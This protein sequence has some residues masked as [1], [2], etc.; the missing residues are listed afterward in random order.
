VKP[1]LQDRAVRL[2][3]PDQSDPLG[4]KASAERPVL[5]DVLAR[6][7]S[8]DRLDLPAPQV[9]L[10]R[11][12]KREPLDKLDLRD[13]LGLLV[14][15]ESK[16]PPAPLV[17]GA[18]PDLLGKPDRQG[19]LDLLERPDLQGRWDL[20]DLQGLPHLLP[21]LQRERRSSR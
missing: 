9:Q 2:V 18:N 20:L 10:V 1:G 7:A 6:K 12:V 3:L 11:R 5:L 4:H 13:L 15:R 14:Q 16:G 21:P 19:L 8:K 17:R